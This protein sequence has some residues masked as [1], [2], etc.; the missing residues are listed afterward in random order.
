MPIYKKVNKDFFKLA[1]YLKKVKQ[2]IL[3]ITTKRSFTYKEHNWS[4][5]NQFLKEEGYLGGKSGYT[6]PAGQTVISMFSVPLSESGT[7]PVGIVLLRSEDRYKDVKNILKFLKKNIYYGGVADANTAWVKQKDGIPE[8]RDPDF[9]TLALLGDI[10][11]D[12]GVKNSVIKNHA[13]DYAALFE[14]PKEMSEIYST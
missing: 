9:V 6:D 11:L 8:I 14:K 7:R 12:R 10:M 4:S 5:S 13:G 1:G 3:F 2:D